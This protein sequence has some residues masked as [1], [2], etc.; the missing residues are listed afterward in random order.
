MEILNEDFK[1]F[2]DRFSSGRGGINGVKTGFSDYLRTST[3]AGGCQAVSR[4]W[5]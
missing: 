3:N 2:E 5:S 4:T 1:S